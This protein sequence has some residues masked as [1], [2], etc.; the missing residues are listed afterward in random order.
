MAPF[1]KTEILSRTLVFLCTL[2]LVVG[3]ASSATPGGDERA[4]FQPLPKQAPAPPDNPTTEA[5]VAL[6]KRLFFDPRLSGNNTISCA[7]CHI[8]RAAFA[9][10]KATSLGADGKALSRNTPTCLNSGFWKNLTWD[11][12]ARSLEEQ[13]LG[14]ITSAAEMNQD[15]TELEKELS[16]IRAYR[17]EFQR[18]FGG[19]PSIG[20]V[21][22]ALAAFERTLVAHSSPFD[23]F[24]AGERSAL[25]KA[26]RRG[27]ELFRGDAGCSDCHHGV[28]LSDEKFYRLGVSFRDAGRGTVTGKA[29]DRYRFR[30]PTLR[31]VADTAPYMHDGSLKTLDDVVMFYF[32]GIPDVAPHGL[33]MDT[34]VRRDQS[35][36]DIPD[37]V[38]FLESLSG[39][40]P[41][42]DPPLLP[43]L[44]PDEQETWISPPALS[45]EGWLVHRVRSPYQSG[46]TTVRVLAPAKG[47]TATTP[48]VLVLPVEPEG[49]SRYGD[50]MAEVLKHDLHNRWQAVFVEPGFSALPW[51]ADHPTQPSVRQESFLL[52]V[53]LPLIRSF[54]KISS[55]HRDWHLLGY[56]KSGWGAWSLLLRHPSTFGKAVAWDAPL[57]M[58][59][60]GKYGN[61]PIFGTQANFERYRITDL[62]RRR[63][64]A[65]A[66]SKRLLLTG[67]GN[68]RRDHAATRDLLVKL[69]IPHEY[70]DGPKRAHHWNSG[71]VEPAVEWLLTPD[72][73]QADR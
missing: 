70:W 39:E 32:R 14:P 58:D 63:R 72:D 28:L 4:K 51:Y 67:Y 27:F 19:Q 41:H 21:T 1:V 60:I 18:V 64:D 34:I 56:S 66:N 36:N 42:V 31:N 59:T 49:S 71:W 61:R 7:T 25:S 43:E 55:N 12:R 62:L 52:N 29:D 37:I 26:A 20:R 16:A 8:P 23:R 22:Q 57:A 48:V 68:F 6:G 33:P 24:L 46:E 35:I 65:L 50:G 9:D 17:Q 2:V 10:H 3:G 73:R 47:T 30:T 44:I 38:A 5:K 69:G 11:G 13:A 45:P 15:V 54:Y 53:I 40:A